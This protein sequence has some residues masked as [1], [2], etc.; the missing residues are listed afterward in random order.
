ALGPLIDLVGVHLFPTL[1]VFLGLLPV[2]AVYC[3]GDRP[4]NWLDVVAAAVTA[5]AVTVQMLADFQLHRFIREHQPGQH[6][7]SGL[8]AWSRHPNYFGELGFWFGMFLFGLAAL[9][10]G[11]YWYGAG[12]AGMVVLFVFGSVPMMERRS[13]E[14]RPD[15]QQVIDSVSMLVPWPPKK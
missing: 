9:P 5:G 10:S 15:Y 6:L 13:L 12:I 2:Y 7:D 11:W 8:W 1:Q 14:R 3:L 4:F